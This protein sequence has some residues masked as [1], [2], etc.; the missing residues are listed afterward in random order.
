MNNVDWSNKKSSQIFF[1]TL[2]FCDIC[3][4]F[5]PNP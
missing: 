4:S 1:K 5:K 3:C 2:K